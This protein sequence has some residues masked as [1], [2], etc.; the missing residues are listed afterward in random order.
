MKN[1]F[2]FLLGRGDAKEPADKGVNFDDAFVALAQC[3]GLQ[4]VVKLKMEWIFGEWKFTLFPIRPNMHTSGP[5]I[6]FDFIRRLEETIQLYYA[7]HPIS[8]N[9]IAFQIGSPRTLREI[10]QDQE[11]W[12][13]HCQFASCD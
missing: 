10:Q 4:N 12:R 5:T 7:S 11:A 9:P 8:G 2:W 3:Y 1:F 6:P 13:R